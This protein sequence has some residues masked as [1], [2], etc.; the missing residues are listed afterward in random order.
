VRARIQAAALSA[1]LAGVAGCG[2]DPGRAE[3]IDLDAVCAALVSEYAAAWPA[4]LTCDAGTIGQCTVLRPEPMRDASGSL[5]GLGCDR[6][7]NRAHVKGLDALLARFDAAGCKVM[8]LPCPSVPDLDELVRRCPAS[9]T[10][11]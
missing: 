4:A 5:D 10:C 11:E 3:R 6:V 1:I 7:V 9:G 8:P 2:A